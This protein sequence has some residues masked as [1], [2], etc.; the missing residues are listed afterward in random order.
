MEAEGDAGVVAAGDVEELRRQLEA[1]THRVTALEGREAVLLA[2]EARRQVTDAL[3]GMRF[4]E[5][6]QV[7]APASRTALVEALMPLEAGQRTAVLEAVKGQQFVSLGERGFSHVEDAGETLS[8]AE[9]AQVRSLAE[10][11]GLPVAEVKAQF[12]EVRRRRAA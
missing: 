3:S 4:G 5:L 6:E 1:A 8:A 7:L 10:R 9:E 2:A 11:N 12:L